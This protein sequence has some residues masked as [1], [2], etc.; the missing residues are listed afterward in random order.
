MN[1]KIFDKVTN[2]GQII[3]FLTLNQGNVPLKIGSAIFSV[4]VSLARFL[5]AIGRAVFNKR[6][7]RKKKIFSALREVAKKVSQAKNLLLP[8]S[9][10]LYIKI[11]VSLVGWCCW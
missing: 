6:V 3:S 4:M 1:Q 2:G 5:Y 8:S 7:P 9:L 10:I 11:L